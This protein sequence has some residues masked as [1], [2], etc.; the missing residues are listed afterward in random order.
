MSGDLLRR[1]LDLKRE[2][3]EFGQGQRFVKEMVR[4]V[5]RNFGEPAVVESEADAILFTDWFILEHL[6][7]DGRTIVDKFVKEHRELSDSDKRMLLGWKRVVEG[8]FEV[9]GSEDG[10][11]LLRDLVDDCRYLAKSNQGTEALAEIRPGSFAIGRLVP[12]EDFWMVSGSMGVLPSSEKDRLY[13]LAYKNR[14]S[15]PTAVFERNPAKL[16]QAWELQAEYREAFIAYFGGDLVITDGASF[17]RKWT[18][19]HHHWTSVRMGKDGS[20]PAERSVRMGSTPGVPNIELPAGFVAADTVGAIFDEKEGINFYTNFALFLEAFERPELAQD[21]EHREALWGYLKSASVS[22]LPFRRVAEMFPANCESVLGG[23]VGNPR[24]RLG[25]DFE[26]LMRRY[27][28]AWIKKTVYPFVMPV[29][30]DMSQAL[31]RAD[32]SESRQQ[33]GPA[34]EQLALMEEEARKGRH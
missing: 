13:R 28:K 8:T 15:N 31:L 7:H 9:E 11:L 5:R 4:E 32:N 23:L 33:R 24:F 27:K 21:R 26:N 3:V 2:L 25:T 14:L 6:L 16:R 17:A 20:T 19:F 12:L 18:E 10:G 22:T 29:E 30:T 1:A 34:L